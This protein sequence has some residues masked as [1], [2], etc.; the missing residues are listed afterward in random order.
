MAPPATSPNPPSVRAVVRPSS[1]REAFAILVVLVTSSAVLLPLSAPGM[2]TTHDGF[3]HVQRMIA[4]EA[5][6]RDG[7]P[8]S[9]WLPDLAY[10]YGQPLLLYYAPL[11]Y[12][13]ALAFRGMGWGY[14][15]S[16]EVGSGLAV[17]L[18]ALTMYLL[19]RSLF[20]RTAAIVAA[21]VYATLPYQM[22]DLYV[23]GALAESWA[24]VWMPL[25]ALCLIRMARVSSVWWGIGFSC[26]LAGLIPTH[27]VTALLFLPALTV[28]AGILYA[29]GPGRS[30]R[31]AVQ[32]AGFLTLGIG[33]SAWF[34]LPALTERILVQI[35]QTIEPALFASFFLNGWPPFRFEPLF[36]YQQPVSTALGYPIFWPQLGLVQAIIA[37]SGGVAVTRLTGVQRTAGIWAALLVIGGMVLQFRPFAFIYDLIPLLAFVQFPWRLLALVGLGS[38]LLAGGLVEVIGARILVQTGAATVI[39]VASVTT[40]VAQLNPQSTPIDERLLSVETIARAELADYGLGTTHSGEYLPV[41]SGQRNAARLR[42]TMLDEGRSE[43]T[44]L[45]PIAFEIEHVDWQP[46]R[47]TVELTST[48]SATEKLMFHQFAFDGWNA[49]VDGLAVRTQALGQL[50]LA[51]VNVTP[52]RH[53]VELFW[54]GTRTTRR[55]QGITVSGLSLA[56]LVFLALAPRI[57]GRRRWL[58]GAGMA[59]MALTLL[60]G[61][62]GLPAWPVQNEPSSQISRWQPID[63]TLALV[64]VRHDL[65]RLASDRLLTTRL[66]WLA[67][68]TPATGYRAILETVAADDGTVHRAPW[69]YEPLSRLWER[70]EVLPTTVATRLPTGFPAGTVQLRLIF[71]QPAGLAPVSLGAVEVPA[72]RAAPALLPATT[73]VTIGSGIRLSSESASEL[74]ARAGAALHVALRWEAL[75]SAPEREHEYLTVAVVQTAG[76]EIVSEVGRPGDWFAPLPFWQAGDVIHQ[77]LRLS[78]PQS[79]PAG[80]YPLTVRVYAR[81]LA[82]GGAAEP[83]ASSA[84]LRGRPLAE[85]AIGTVTVSP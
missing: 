69:I 59:F 75:V 14:I 10:G 57:H 27:N 23:R 77:R 25:S 49:T 16:F 4:L 6:A 48:S 56:A 78:L 36:D 44:L 72:D 19:A 29:A 13:P 3:L 34:W 30:R 28:L 58:V 73:G 67:R 51:G 64:D 24:F 2:V 22:V 20:G 9:R 52:G 35:E 68:Q 1:I 63:E 82:R 70:G 71:E 33:L 26:S 12:L 37:V 11:S 53:T 15:A 66:T 62:P 76:G 80:G 32:T 41:S 31:F 81:D 39:V 45:D 40:A 85:L 8:F 38:A 7:A 21:V 17:V 65:S 18:S 5:V 42:K 46:D 50:G 54:S 74:S 43:T 60:I 83:G 47:I 84:R 79:V 55:W 61:R